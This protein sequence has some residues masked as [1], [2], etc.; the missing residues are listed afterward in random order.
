VAGGVFV[1]DLRSRDGSGAKSGV[2]ELASLSGLRGF[3]FAFF[4]VKSFSLYGKDLLT[5]KDATT[6][7]QLNI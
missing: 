7:T 4:A 1:R 5:A 2:G 3:Y 6:T